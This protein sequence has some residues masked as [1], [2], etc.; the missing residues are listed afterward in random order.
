M[1][2]SRI[3]TPGSKQLPLSNG[4]WIRVKTRLSAG[5]RHDSYELMYLRNPD[6]SYVVN[7][8]GRLIVGPANS[9]RA[10][11]VAYLLDWSL[12]GPDGSPLVVRGA[13]P[14]EI[15]AMLRAIDEE[16]FD[17]ISTAILA[18]EA[19]M[20]AERAAQKKILLAP[21]AADPTSPSPSVPAGTLIESAG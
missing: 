4:D 20:A 2:T 6:G 9:R 18:H 11:I 13:S 17:E 3:V 21:P 7:A 1:G 16:S 12:T 10:Q 8:D 19:A 5:E 15:V 14:E